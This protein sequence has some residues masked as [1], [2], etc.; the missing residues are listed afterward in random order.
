MALGLSVVLGG[1]LRIA[2]GVYLSDCAVPLRPWRS[3]L[4]VGIGSF[5]VATATFIVRHTAGSLSFQPLH[6]PSLR[7]WG[8]ASL[9]PSW[10]NAEWEASSI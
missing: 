7:H 6:I 5:G 1:A 10:A 9:A 4:I 8:R 2:V 3:A